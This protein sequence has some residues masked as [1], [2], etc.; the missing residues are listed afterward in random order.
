MENEQSQVLEDIAAKCFPSLP[1]LSNDPFVLRKQ[2]MAIE[3]LTANPVP[4][5]LLPK[6]NQAK[7]RSGN[8]RRVR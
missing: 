2:R 5:H 6:K 8:R 7:V 3:F 1:D 4:K